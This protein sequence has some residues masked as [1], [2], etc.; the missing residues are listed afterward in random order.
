MKWNVMILSTSVRVGQAAANVQRE[1]D[2]ALELRYTSS[3][4]LLDW[5][6]LLIASMRSLSIKSSFGVYGVGYWDECKYLQM[7]SISP[8]YRSLP[9]VS[10]IT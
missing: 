2:R 3:S 8:V 6:V 10:S 1:R 4:K 7:K 5:L 9:S